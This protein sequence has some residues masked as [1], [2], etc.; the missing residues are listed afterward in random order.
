VADA[1]LLS[2]AETLVDFVKLPLTVPEPVTLAVTDAE[3]VR[4]AVTDVLTVDDGVLSVQPWNPEQY[5]QPSLLPLP[6]FCHTS[7]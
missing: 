1:V 4:D 2:V 5:W 7:M 3:K 6:G